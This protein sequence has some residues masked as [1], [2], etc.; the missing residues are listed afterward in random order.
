MTQALS[1]Y[2]GHR[3]DTVGNKTIILSMFKD[4]QYIQWD[5]GHRDSVDIGT[6]NAYNPQSTRLTPLTRSETTSRRKRPRSE[7]IGT[8]I[9]ESR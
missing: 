8:F 4:T 9:Q 5:T 1:E 3:I 7:N 6:Q 2:F